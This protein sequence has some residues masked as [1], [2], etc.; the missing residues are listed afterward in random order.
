SD[1][2]TTSIYAFVFPCSPSPLSQSTTVTDSYGCMRTISAIPLAS[3]D[4][5]SALTTDCVNP[6]SY[7]IASAGTFYA[8]ITV[9][10]SNNA[11]GIVSEHPESTSTSQT[12]SVG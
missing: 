3:G 10:W 1:G 6:A 9:T 11:S 7:E 12:F 5:A 4:T 8:M 2:R